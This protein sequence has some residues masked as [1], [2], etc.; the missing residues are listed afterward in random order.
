MFFFNPIFKNYAKNN[1]DL[2]Y[3]G[4]SNKS[5]LKFIIKHDDRNKIKISRGSFTSLESSLLILEKKETERIE[6]VH[7]LEKAD[8]VISNFR[9]GWGKIKNINLL[10]ERFTIIHDI[11]V[12]GIIINSIYKKNN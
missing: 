7:D 2:D 10:D 12:D 3:W 9:K 1:F 4:V 6:I 11:K 5:A 8:Y